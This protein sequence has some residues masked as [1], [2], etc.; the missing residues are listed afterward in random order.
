VA[1]KKRIPRTVLQKV[2]VDATDDPPSVHLKLHGAGGSHTKLTVPKNRTGYHSHINSQEV[3]ALIRELALVCEN[4]SI[5]SILNRPGDRTGNSNPGR[6]SACR[7][8]AIQTALL[9]F[10]HQ[11]SGCG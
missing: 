5:V 3:T 6:R 4:A 1:L 11:I 9:P 7:M 8:S 10:H 2:M